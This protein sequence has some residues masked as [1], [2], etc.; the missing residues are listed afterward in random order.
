MADLRAVTSIE[1]ADGRYTAVLSPDYTNMNGAPFGGYLAAL[2][3]RAAG[4][5]SSLPRPATFQAQF[6]NA[7]EIRSVDIRVSTLR[8]SKRSEAIRVSMSQGEKP[9]AEAMIWTVGELDGLDHGPHVVPSAPPPESLRSFRELYANYPDVGFTRQFEVRPVMTFALDG[10]RPDGA[11]PWD[12][13]P[14]MAGEPAPQKAET[15]G[16]FRL[17]EQ[18]G[19][20]DPY[21]DGGR[22]LV[23]L[24]F[25]PIGAAQMPNTGKAMVFLPTLSLTATFHEPAGTEWLYCE[26]TSPIAKSGLVLADGTVWSS[27]GRLVATGNQQC[28]QR[29]MTSMPTMS[30]DS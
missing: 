25:F 26:A 7:A 12:M 11:P 5:H 20:D 18:S 10:P 1:G 4:V 8:S 9:I 24:D 13:S 16:W 6:L 30:Q 21:V 17:N 19:L 14:F 23:A 15:K 2:L 3:L 29:V 27:D 22:M 28:F